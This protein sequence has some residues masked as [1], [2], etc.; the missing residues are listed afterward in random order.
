[1]FGS[2][3]LETNSE[4]AQVLIS[5]LQATGVPARLRGKDALFALLRDL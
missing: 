4:E 5:S 1:M 2:P 3:V